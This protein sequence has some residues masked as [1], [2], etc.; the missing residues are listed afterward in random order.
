MSGVDAILLRLAFG[1]PSSNDAIV[2]EVDA[3]MRALKEREL[4]GGPLVL[5]NGA[6]SLPVIAAISHHVAHL[7]GAVGIFDPKLSSYVIVISH[8]HNFSVGDTIAPS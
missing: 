1:D 7:F 3:R 4:T 5:L 8:G 6:A 2:R